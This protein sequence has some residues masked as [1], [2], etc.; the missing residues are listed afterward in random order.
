MAIP[1]SLL[2]T[3]LGQIDDIST[4][5]TMDLKEAG[6]VLYLVGQTRDELGGSHFALVNGLEGGNVPD[7]D[8][9]LAPRIFTALHAAIAH[10]LVRSCHDLSEGGLAAAVAEMAFAGGLGV[11]IDLAGAARASR[12][13]D[14][15][16]L[17]F[18]ESNTRFVI[19]VEPHHAA[20]IE[21]RFAQLPLVPLGTVTQSESIRIT[22]HDGPV[23][24]DVGWP[25][26]KA[27]WQK[28]LAWD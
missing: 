6:N 27:A 14:N 1:A 8:L 16:V 2:I 20:E 9:E 3:A 28:P 22:G 11:A 26:L 4:A 10:G 17:L 21:R 13:A 15:A 24:V 7:V 5:V 18:S 23:C 12:L 19:E 25:E